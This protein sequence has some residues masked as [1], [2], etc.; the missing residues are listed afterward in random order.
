MGAAEGLACFFQ[1]DN[2]NV[3]KIV[4]RR[5]K[6]IDCDLAAVPIAQ[7][8]TEHFL[9]QRFK[10]V[11]P[12]GIQLKGMP[13]QRTLHRIGFF[14]ISFA[15]I[16][17]AKRRWPGIDSLFESAINTFF[18]FLAQIANEVG[19]NDGLNVGGKSPAARVEI[20]TF[21]GKMDFDSL[22]DEIA[23]FGPVG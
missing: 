1:L 7:S 6:A 21:I 2:P 20:Q 19:C 15:L 12:G 23:K 9:G 11:P 18:R 8:H 10:V 14:W 5:R 17:I 3:K 4:Q 22:V 13:Q 16:Q